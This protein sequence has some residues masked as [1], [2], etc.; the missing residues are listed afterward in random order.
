[1]QRASIARAGDPSVALEAVDPCETVLAMLERVLDVLRLDPE[2]P[3][4]RRE[5]ERHGEQRQVPDHRV[6]LSKA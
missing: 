2:D 6:L 4:A 3:G 5:E 1:M